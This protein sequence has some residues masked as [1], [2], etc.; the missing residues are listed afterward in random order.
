MARLTRRG[1][2]PQR[3]PDRRDTWSLV[4][5]LEVPGSRGRL[6]VRLGRSRPRAAGTRSRPAMPLGGGPG[7]GPRARRSAPGTAARPRGGACVCPPAADRS[8]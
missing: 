2:R 1:A 3:A 4:C 5:A 7:P 6:D 8:L